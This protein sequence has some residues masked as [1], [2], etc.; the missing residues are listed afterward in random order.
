MELF[1]PI[2]LLI[3]AAVLTTAPATATEPPGT[4]AA[5]ADAWTELPDWSGT[6]WVD[7]P[8]ILDTSTVTPAAA[9]GATP[10]DRTHPPY[11]P[12]FE[13]RYQD[14]IERRKQ[15]LPADPAKFCMPAGMPR[16]LSWPFGVEFH[17]TPEMTHITWEFDA[18]V[19]RIYTDGRESPN[20]EEI[21]PTW[22]GYSI[23]HWEGDT[24]VVETVGIKEPRT[25]DGAPDQTIDRT[26]GVLSGEH[27][28]SERIRK[29]AQDTME[30]DVTITDPV[31]L[32]RPW[33]F[34]K[35]FRRARAGEFVSDYI[36]CQSPI[37]SGKTKFPLPT[38]RE[39]YFQ[40][41]LKDGP[42]SPA[43]VAEELQNRQ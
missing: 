19:R 20:I 39:E 29:T 38:T 34:K 11:T 37:I 7:H 13:K 43:R 22:T 23:G 3:A 16:L 30:I 21:F 14:V 33:T 15:G 8:G 5:R 36:F 26:G 2:A 4:N 40:W 24:L 9:D 17:V 10:G 6:W 27:R 35:T 18:Q 32:T 12:E 25:I 28:I 41:F 1:K 42:N 31:A